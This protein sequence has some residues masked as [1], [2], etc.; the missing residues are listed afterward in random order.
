MR[1]L[2]HFVQIKKREKTRG[3]V[4]L[5]LKLQA[6]ETKKLYQIAQCI[7][8]IDVDGKKT[9]WSAEFRNNFFFAKLTDRKI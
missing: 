9:F 3:G 7:T 6:L 8:Y 5:L 2:L 4:L 1:D